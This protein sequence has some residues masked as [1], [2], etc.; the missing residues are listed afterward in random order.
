MQQNSRN[1][2]EPLS[3]NELGFLRKKEAGQR[4]VFY[5]V[6]R[7]LMFISF[8]FP[9]ALAWYRA[10]DGV[11]N[12]FS[13]VKFFV[14]AAILLFVS[15]LSTYFTYRVYLRKVTRDIR[16]QT[17]TIA[18]SRITRKVYVQQNGSYF[19][20]LDSEIKLSIEVSGDDF[21][22][23]QEGDEVNIEYTTWSREYLGYF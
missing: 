14:I 7:I 21:N 9:F 22:F 17:K 20:Y 6:F 18:P 10:A 12:A 19:F 23:F 3:S 2:L 4:K 16:E 1:Y 13:Y 11:T 5:M 15:L 8:L